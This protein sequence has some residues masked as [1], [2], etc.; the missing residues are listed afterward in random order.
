M[1]A[2]AA[3]SQIHESAHQF[4]KPCNGSLFNLTVRVKQS[5]EGQVEGDEGRGIAGP[6]KP[7]QVP[8]LCSERYGKPLT[9]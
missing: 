4:Q 9:L 1:P 8:G 3:M 5:E 7:M 2:I 6:W